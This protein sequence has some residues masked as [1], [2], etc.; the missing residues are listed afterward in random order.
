MLVLYNAIRKDVIKLSLGKFSS[1]VIEKSFDL[2]P[3]PLKKRLTREIFF[4]N[5]VHSMLKN[6]SGILILKKAIS[7][8]CPVSRIEA[9]NLIKDKLKKDFTEPEI[10]NLI[11]ILYMLE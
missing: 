4:C 3:L 8:L 7:T 1:N 2:F 6:K 9:R 11:S 5:K 10:K